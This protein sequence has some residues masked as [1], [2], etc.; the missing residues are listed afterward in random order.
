MLCLASLALVKCA[1]F[2]S[3]P[4]EAKAI[5]PL[6]QALLLEDAAFFVGG[7]KCRF[8]DIPDSWGA[9][10]AM[11]IRYDPSAMKPLD[12]SKSAEFVAI[13]NSSNDFAM[14]QKNPW[15]PTEYKHYLLLTSQKCPFM[16]I[17]IGE[18][19]AGT[20][21]IIFQSV[22]RVRADAARFEMADERFLY[23]EVINKQLSEFIKGFAVIK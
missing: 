17:A 3:V 19:R 1:D 18:L 9:A 6:S 23:C 7:A 21:V 16:A 20:E 13:S 2:G 11:G 12:E 22:V 5:V 15:T 8:Q 10:S 14:K 4:L